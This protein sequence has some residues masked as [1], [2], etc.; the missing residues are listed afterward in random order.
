[1]VYSFIPPM[2]NRIATEL[3]K[4][5]APDEHTDKRKVKRALG[6]RFTDHE[7]DAF[8]NFKKQSALPQSRIH[9]YRIRTKEA[10]SFEDLDT[11]QSKLYDSTVTFIKHLDRSERRMLAGLLQNV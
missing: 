5:L 9:R 7:I 8:I 2:V 11:E 1:M 10:D 3:S 6:D 4:S